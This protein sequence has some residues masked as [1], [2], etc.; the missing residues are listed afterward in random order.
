MT[1]LEHCGKVSS[2][3]HGSG[4]AHIHQLAIPVVV[5]N[6]FLVDLPNPF[7][8]EAPGPQG[9][10][11]RASSA[12]GRELDDAVEEFC[13]RIR[14][15]MVEGGEALLAPVVYGRREGIEGA[16]ERRGDAIGPVLVPARM[17]SALF[18]AW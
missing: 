3:I 4:E 5:W 16:L 1:P 11:L 8:E 6:D 14:V 18:G 9:A 12:A 2:E 17:A 13:D 10:E 7:R 15:A